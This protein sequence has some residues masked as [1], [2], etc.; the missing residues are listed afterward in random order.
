VVSLGPGEHARQE[1]ASDRVP[2]AMLGQQWGGE[3][4]T[5]RV[6][7]AASDRVPTAVAL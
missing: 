6:C 7:E 3:P 2:T 4:R 5:G 1:V